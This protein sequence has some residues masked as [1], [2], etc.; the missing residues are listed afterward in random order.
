MTSH[1]FGLFQGQ[2]LEFLVDLGVLKTN[3]KPSWPWK[4]SQRALSLSM[5]GV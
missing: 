4:A 3:P 1:I 5:V 2:V